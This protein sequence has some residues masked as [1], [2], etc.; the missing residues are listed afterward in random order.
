MILFSPA[1]I[2]IGLQIIMH[3]EDGFHNL[4][5]IM[6]PVGLCDIL[7]IRRSPDEG[8][9]IRFSQSGIQIDPH[10]NKN[11]C[12]QAWELFTQ[13]VPLPAVD[14][15]LHK[16][17]P[18][19]AGLG[20]GS[21]NA[22]TTLKGLNILAGDPLPD[23]MLHEMAATLGSD[24]PFF[25]HEGPMLMEGRGDILSSISPCLD[26]LYLILL[27]PGIHVS[28]AEAYAGVKPAVP[29]QH[30][31]ELIRQP[32]DRWREFVINDFEH[33]VFKRYPELDRLKQDLYGA[34]AVYASLSGSGSSLYGIFPESPDLPEEL[35]QYLI[36]RGTT[37]SSTETR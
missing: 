12:I 10:N 16:Q 2:N 5:S 25:L 32:M 4:Q 18:V 30:L 21:S 9:S 17:I 27:F 22:S 14:L 1:K 8:D 36:W 34:G 26:H 11:L 29:N 35:E 24:C 37:V 33:S 3:R 13:E 31:Q 20:G 15:H 6:Y 7:E 23:E 28:T 19:G